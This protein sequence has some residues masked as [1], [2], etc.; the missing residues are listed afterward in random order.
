MVARFQGLEPG[1]VSRSSRK[2]VNRDIGRSIS[3]ADL[4][5]AQNLARRAAGRLTDPAVSADDITSMVLIAMVENQELPTLSAVMTMVSNVNN[6][7]ANRTERERSVSADRKPVRRRRFRRSVGYFRSVQI[8]RQIVARGPGLTEPTDGPGLW[9][10]FT[11]QTGTVDYLPPM[12]D[13]IGSVSSVGRIGRSIGFGLHSSGTD[14]RRPVYSVRPIDRLYSTEPG[15]FGPVRSVVDTAVAGLSMRFATVVQAIL[16]DGPI[17]KPDVDT[18]RWFAGPVVGPSENETTIATVRFPQRT[19]PSV[20]VSVGTVARRQIADHAAKSP[21]RLNREPN[22][23]R[24]LDK[25]KLTANRPHT[26]AT[27]VQSRPSVPSADGIGTREW[28]SRFFSYTVPVVGPGSAAMIGRS[29]R[30]SGTTVGR[31]AA[32]FCYSP[33]TGREPRIQ[34]SDAVRSIGLEPTATVRGAFAGLVLLAATAAGSAVHGFPV[35]DGSGPID[36]TEPVPVCP[37]PTGAPVAVTIGSRFIGPIDRTVV[38][39]RPVVPERPVPSVV[40]F[41]AGF[42]RGRSF[43]AG[44]VAVSAVPVRPIGQNRILPL[45][46]MVVWI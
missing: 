44:S 18:G 19:D 16:S 13:R 2:N 38:S 23:S 37:V 27:A 45:T 7:A 36:R 15:Q 20:P 46:E 30:D 39:G 1:H 11:V 35:P 6:S 17:A 25:R 3:P 22:L 29:L 26:E 32:E 34:Y 33:S 10:S 43:I 31:V 24:M 40:R 8:A 41:A 42:A 4:T 12:F 28:W 9:F 21:V 14:D 5:I